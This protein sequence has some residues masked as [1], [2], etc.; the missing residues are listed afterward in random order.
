MSS[1]FLLYVA[2]T[3]MCKGAIDSTED[4]LLLKCGEL[5]CPCK[6]PDMTERSLRAELRKKYY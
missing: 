6:N 5:F 4:G 3:A 2:L 1:K